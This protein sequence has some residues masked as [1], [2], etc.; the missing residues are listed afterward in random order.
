MK[1]QFI[2]VG[3]AF[4]PI[5]RGNSNMLLTMDNG[6]RIMF[7][8][9]TTAPYILRDEMKID[10]RD[11]DGVY[12][13]HCHADHAGGLEQFALSRHFL[14]KIDA[15]GDIVK[16]KLYV[17]Y[18][19]M[20]DGLWDKTLSGGLGFLKGEERN[21]SFYFDVICEDEEF[22]IGDQILQ[23]IEMEHVM[24]SYGLL[25]YDVFSS[26]GSRVLITSDCAWSDYRIDLY[27]QADWIFHDTETLDEASGVHAH[28]KDLLTL[29][30]HIRKKIWMYHYSREIETWKADGFAGFATKGQEFTT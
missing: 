13:S 11:I 2:G 9:G 1:I 8:F 15:N 5:S 6:E 26:R 14:P 19:V 7:D 28:Y 21:L 27:E 18:R 22:M 16:P 12:V 30:E 17:P 4:A 10:F 3:G 24:N 20:D 25:I 29:P 23:I